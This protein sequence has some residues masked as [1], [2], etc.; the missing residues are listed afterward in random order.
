MVT[1]AFTGLNLSL[2]ALYSSKKAMNVT[3]ENIANAVTQLVNNR[4]RIPL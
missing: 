3:S 4:A 2:R 1:G